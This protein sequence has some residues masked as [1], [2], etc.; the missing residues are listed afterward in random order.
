MAPQ[1]CDPDLASARRRVKRMEGVNE[2]NPPYYCIKKG[3]PLYW[4]VKRR[5]EVLE[6][7]M[8][9]YLA[10]SHVLGDHLAVDKTKECIISRIYW[11]GITSDVD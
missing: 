3:F 1:L 5:G 2:Q 6:H 4:V 10:H 7:L 11:P 9:L 8:V